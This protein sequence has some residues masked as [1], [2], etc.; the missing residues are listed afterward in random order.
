MSRNR[1]LLL[2]DHT[3][4]DGQLARTGGPGGRGPGE[5]GT[6]AKKRGHKLPQRSH[7]QTGAMSLLSTVLQ[8]SVLS[9]TFG[10]YLWSA[11]CVPRALRSPVFKHCETEAQKATVTCPGHTAKRMA[12]LGLQAKGLLLLPQGLCTCCPRCLPRPL[13]ISL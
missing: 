8:T 3:H 5:G 2:T 12:K 11:R 6:L 10:K 13:P 9:S 4:M 1:P 7:P